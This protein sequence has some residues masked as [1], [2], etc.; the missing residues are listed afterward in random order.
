[1]E[2]CEIKQR[3][4]EL[5]ADLVQVWLSAVKATHTFLSLQEIEHIQKYVPQALNQVPHLLVLFEKEKPVAFMG[6]SQQKLEMLFVDNSQ[7][8][9][10][11]GKQLLNYGLKNYRLQELVVNEQNP[12]ARGFYEHM[13]F[14]VY[15]RLEYDEQ[16]QP[17]P[18]LLMQK[19]S[20]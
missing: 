18:I 10:G 5:I 16:N 19:K 7:R 6:I 8:G 1:M 2:I 3:S 9:H 20:D 11:L 17:Y 4:P 15:Q 13:G 12:A 14:K